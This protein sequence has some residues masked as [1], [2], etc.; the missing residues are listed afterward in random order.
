MPFAVHGAAAQ[1][2]VEELWR[3]MAFSILITNVDDHLL[4]HG[5]LHAGHGQWRLAPAFDLNP[6]PDRVRELKTWISPE[7]GPRGDDRRLLSVA[8]YF[9]ISQARAKGTLAHVERAVAG[10]RERRAFDRDDRR[11]ARA[12]CPGLRAP[13][14]QR[15]RRI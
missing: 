2:D 10:W 5:F 14:A 6:F 9:K 13:G 3:R 12:V 8:P 1:H 4:N 7:T 11:R 15:A